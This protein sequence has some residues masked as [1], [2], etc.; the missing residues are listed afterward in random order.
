MIALQC[1]VYIQRLLWWQDDPA[2]KLQQN[3]TQQIHTRMRMKPWDARA[4][5]AHLVF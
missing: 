4:P 3:I 1:K 2:H 5:T